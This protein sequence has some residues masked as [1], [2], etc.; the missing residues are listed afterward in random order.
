MKS[1]INRIKDL[2]FHEV[3]KT[4]INYKEQNQAEGINVIK[5]RYISKNSNFP[6]PHKISKCLGYLEEIGMLNFFDKSTIR[7]RYT[8]IEDLWKGSYEDVMKTI[9][10]KDKESCF[11]L[12]FELW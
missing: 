2:G 1:R 12:I 9:I 5:T 6:S 11:P 7:T 8:L 3:V 4:I 10:E